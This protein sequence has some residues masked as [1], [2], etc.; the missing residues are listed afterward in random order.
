MDSDRLPCL[1]SHSMS[2]G[3]SVGMRSRGLM[4]GLFTPGSFL[5]RVSHHCLHKTVFCVIKG[6]LVVVIS[7]PHTGVITIFGVLCN[8]HR[9]GVVTVVVSKT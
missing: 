7:I 9:F 6:C 8:K 3:S 5:S 2:W 1:S 4:L